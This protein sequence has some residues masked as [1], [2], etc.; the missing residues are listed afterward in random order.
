MKSE[1]KQNILQ[2]FQALNISGNGQ[3]SRQELLQCILCQE[4]ISLIQSC[5]VFRNRSG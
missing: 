4:I 3:I 2:K 5:S 1:E